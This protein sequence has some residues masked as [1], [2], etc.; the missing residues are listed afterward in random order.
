LF[1][2]WTDCSSTIG[3]GDNYIQGRICTLH[4]S[5]TVS[6]E[7]LE[8]GHA[9][10]NAMTTSHTPGRLLSALL[11]AGG[12]ALAMAPTALADPADADAAGTDDPGP[13]MELPGVSARPIEDG[14]APQATVEA[15][16]AFSVALNYAA[17]NYEDFAYNTAGGGNTV[18]YTD[19]SVVS[20]NSV[21]RTA[22]RQAASMSMSAAT[23]PGLPPDIADPMRS[24]SLRAA[25]MVLIMGLHGGGDTLNSTATDMNTDAHDV[26]MA[27]A[28]A[29]T[30]V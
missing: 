16:K 8:T 4:R 11:L 18:N 14:D 13:A 6:I 25:K 3:R 5:P 17:S 1:T 27:C 24:W 19:G 28:K 10:R 21:G 20:A 30:V 12:I 9:E 7:Q 26:Q 2:I 29:G 15:C 23:T 22:L